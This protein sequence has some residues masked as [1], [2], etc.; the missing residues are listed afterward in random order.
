MGSE[1]NTYIPWRG[2]WSGPPA[3]RSPALACS[4]DP[5]SPW[6]F[7]LPF[8]ETWNNVISWDEEKGIIVWPLRLLF[9]LKVFDLFVVLG[10][11]SA[12]VTES[13]QTWRHSV[14]I[15]LQG[16]NGSNYNLL[17]IND[18]GYTDVQLSS[19]KCRPLLLVT[20]SRPRCCAPA[21]RRS[22]SRSGRSSAFGLPSC[23]RSI[24]SG[25]KFSTLK[26][27]D[28]ESAQSWDRWASKT[29]SSLV[30]VGCLNTGSAM[31]QC[32]AQKSK[33]TSLKCSLSDPECFWTISKYDAMICNPRSTFLLLC[34]GPLLRYDVMHRA[35]RF[36]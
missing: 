32:C 25:R 28:E 20:F 27:V 6:P 5:S 13:A 7:P 4:R 33:L 3:S 23:L 18:I 2:A 19:V 12:E 31:M 35:G 10:S 11:V 15:L 14:H 30:S 1:Q 21:S 8:H 22:R 16:V 36:V 26:S 34:F 29:S 24:Q 9:L 17:L